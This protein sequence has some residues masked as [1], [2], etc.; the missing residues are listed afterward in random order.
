MMMI[1]M[2]A[3]VMTMTMIQG[4]SEASND[5]GELASGSEEAEER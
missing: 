3:I 4:L 5:I 2:V 1:V